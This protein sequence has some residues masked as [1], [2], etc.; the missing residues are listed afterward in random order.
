[1]ANLVGIHT[2]YPDT[3]GA[4]F[5][6]IYLKTRLQ[7]NEINRQ[8]QFVTK[9]EQQVSEKTASLENQARELATALE[10]AN[11]A[12]QL[13]SEFLANMSHEIRTPM[14]GVIGMLNLLKSTALNGEQAHAVEVAN[15]SAN[16]LLTLINDILD[17]SKIEADKLELEHLEFELRE[18][19]E[20]LVESLALSAHSKGVEVVLDLAELKDV[21]VKSDPGRIR[22]ILS[23]ILSNA[24]KFTEQGEI[25]ITAHLQPAKQP[26]YAYFHCQIQDT[27]IGIPQQKQAILF[28]AFSQVDASTTRKYGGTGLG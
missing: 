15:A 8:K 11:A 24:I 12:T 14:N 20:L 2:V 18:L 17:F 6:T 28:D 5:L 4:Y 21:K 13:K 27:G 7:K 19:I 9:L 25:V 16:S 23:N 1:M 10:Q 22:Q 26:G 3:I